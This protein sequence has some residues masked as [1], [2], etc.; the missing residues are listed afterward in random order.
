MGTFIQDVVIHT[1]EGLFEGT[2]PLGLL[3]PPLPDRFELADDVW[4]GELDDQI[5]DMVLDACDPPGWGVEKP[6]RQFG[7]LYAYVREPAPSIQTW[8]SDKRLLTC[9]ALSRIVHPTS[10][11][12]RYAA[13]IIY[14]SDG[15]VKVVPGPVQGHG[16]DAW[17]PNEHDRDWL[18]DTDL[19]LL[20]QLVRELPTANLP[21]RVWRAFWYHEFAART[22][23]ADVRCT[24]I[25]TG[26]EA[27]VHT[28]RSQSTRQFT[29]RVPRLA[30]D[31]R[32]PN[33][34]RDD[35]ETAYDLR[36]RLSHGQGLAIFTQA[37]RQIYEQ[38]ESVL[39]AAIRRAIL[40]KQFA[41][42]FSSEDLIRGRW[43]LVP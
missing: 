37:E 27:L 28:D 23:Y 41:L 4:I 14:N 5:A 25:V 3:P 20:K 22:Q 7:Q 6:K 11:S 32:A 19:E 42:V 43:P 40:D 36:S 12:F 34:S 30:A 8:D 35:A 13:Q 31:V 9:V 18:N 10:V 26:L 15:T 21:P 16:A 38:I 24:L 29:E 33:S 1:N 2:L 39:R 17:P